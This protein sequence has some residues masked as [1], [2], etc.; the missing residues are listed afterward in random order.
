MKLTR[1]NILKTLKRNKCFKYRKASW[2]FSGEYSNKAND[3]FVVKKAYNSWRG[4][5]Y[6]CQR[7]SNSYKNSSVKWGIE[8][9]ISW[10]ANQLLTRD[11]WYKPVCGRNGDTG[12]YCSSNVRLIESGE[13]STERNNLFDYTKAKMNT[14]AAN[15]A[16]RLKGQLRIKLINIKTKKIKIFDFSKDADIWLGKRIG[17]IKEQLFVKSIARQTETKRNYWIC[18]WDK[19][20]KLWI[21]HKNKDKIQ[22]RNTNRKGKHTTGTQL[23]L[24]LNNTVIKDFKS[25]RQLMK[26]TKRDYI[27]IKNRLTNNKPFIIKGETTKYVLKQKE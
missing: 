20:S 19:N 7:A 23:Q 21:E 2:V 4:Q 9:Y 14:R 1:E 26:E 25:L 5:Q 16:T 15:E 6:S 8:E 18:T 10:Y 17:Y 27:Y 22:N 13:N 24:I 11:Y 12:N 3:C